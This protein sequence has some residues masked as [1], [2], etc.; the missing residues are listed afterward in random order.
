MHNSCDLVIRSVIAGLFAVAFVG[1]VVDDVYV[2]ATDFVASVVPSTGIRA[3]TT[4]FGGS[5]ENG[6]A[7]WTAKVGQFGV[8]CGTMLAGNVEAVVW[9]RWF[10]SC[11]FPVDGGVFGHTVTGVLSF[12]E[13][14]DD[15]VTDLETALG[16][17]FTHVLGVAADVCVFVARFLDSGMTTLGTDSLTESSILGFVDFDVTAHGTDELGFLGTVFSVFATDGSIGSVDVSAIF[18]VEIFGLSWMSCL[19]GTI[20]LQES[21]FA[22]LRAFVDFAAVMPSPDLLESV[23]TFENSDCVFLALVDREDFVSD[24]L[25]MLVENLVHGLLC[26]VGRNDVSGVIVARGSAASVVASVCDL[27]H[28]VSCILEMLLHFTSSSLSGPVVLRDVQVEVD[29]TVVREFTDLVVGDVLSPP[30]VGG[31]HEVGF[32]SEGSVTSKGT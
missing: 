32:V 30:V 25:S 5:D 21:P 26:V 24:P 11:A 28:A 17:S 29:V 19:F 2:F 31:Q 7:T 13:E 10:V 3:P 8:T 18:V 27:D 6:F 1:C 9:I 14:A 20:I 15:A 23:K 22:K 4:I 16:L 12:N